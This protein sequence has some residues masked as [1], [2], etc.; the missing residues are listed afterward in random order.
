MIRAAR[1]TILAL[2]LVATGCT[3]LAPQ[4]HPTD[5]E[6]L[7]QIEDREER[8]QALIDNSIYRENEARGLRYTKGQ[9]LGARSRNWQSLDLILRSDRNSAAAL[10]ERKIRVARVLTGMVVASALVTVGGFAASAREGLDLSR[11]NGTG[12]VLLTGGVLTLGFGIA[13]GITWGQAKV[14]YDRAVDVY[15]DSLGLRLGIYDGDGGYRPPPGVLVDEEGFIILDQKELGVPQMRGE[16]KPPAPVVNPP[17]E[18]PEDPPEDPAK[19]AVEGPK[20]DEAA[21]ETPSAQTVGQTAGRT[22]TN[23]APRL[24]GPARAF[25]GP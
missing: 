9:R 12:A 21:P 3:G 14:G 25:V 7:E 13:A 1:H 8:E 5:I 24:V 17:L 20:V 11:I 18:F 2:T 4:L 15:N 22:R 23:G 19:G 10:P 6:S 16:P